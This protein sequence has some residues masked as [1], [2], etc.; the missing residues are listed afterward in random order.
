MVGLRQVPHSNQDTQASIESYHGALKHWFSLET[1]GLRGRR[2]D[3]LVWRLTT[4]VI[5]H[6]MHIAEMKKRGF[7]RNKVVERI[8][9]TSVEKATLIPHTNVTHGINDS[10]ET[11]HAWMVQSLQHPNMTYEVPLPFTKYACC[12][13]EWAL[14]GNLCKHK[15]AIFFT[16]TC[17]NPTLAKCEGEAQHLEKLGIWSPPGLPNVQSS[18]AGPKTPCIGVFLVSLERS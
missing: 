11:G 7:I 3:W 17:R 2:I 15:V 1:K 8:V 13:C 18:T 4:T 10:N 14:R 5:R 12:T 9:K 6:Y 16:C